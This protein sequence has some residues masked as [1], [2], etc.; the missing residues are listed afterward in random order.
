M[1]TTDRIKEQIE[2]LVKNIET[3]RNEENI[4]LPTLMLFETMSNYFDS[5]DFYRE[6]ADRYTKL[7]LPYSYSTELIKTTNPIVENI[8][9]LIQLLSNTNSIRDKELADTFNVFLNAVQYA[10]VINDQN[11]VKENNKEQDYEFDTYLGK[12]KSVD[13]VLDDHGNFGIKFEL[14]LNG[15]SMGTID[16]TKRWK[17]QD[18]LKSFDPKH[19]KWSKL[20]TTYH[21]HK[22]MIE[23]ENLMKDAKVT[24]MTELNGVAI[25]ANFLEFTL[26]NFRILKEVL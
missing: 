12:I 5:F 6:F 16:N 25:E 7:S 21:C 17:S 10:Q 14:S 20:T 15:G 13:I 19:T 8:E 26:K 1:N 24:K 4:T 9:S 22:S 18:T 2:K 23:L 3:I 11:Y